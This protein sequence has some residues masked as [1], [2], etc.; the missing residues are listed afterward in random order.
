MGDYCGLLVL[1]FVTMKFKDSDFS[2]SMLHRTEEGYLTGRIRCTCSGV[3]RY[4]GTDGE[5]VRVLRSDT[6]V[7]DPSSVMSA[8][9]KPVTLQHPKDMVNAGNVKKYEVGFTGTD[10][11][12]YDGHLWLT[13]TVTDP[14][15]I[16]AIEKG[17]V[18]AV[19]MGYDCDLT[20]NDDPLNNWRGTEYTKEQHNIRYNHLALV[21]A[22]RA[23]ESVE[24]AIGDSIDAN[25]NIKTQRKDN[26]MRKIQIDSVEYEADEVVINAYKAAQKDSAE[27]QKAIDTLT[28]ERD[29]AKALCEQK[30]KEINALKDA[31]ASIDVKSMVKDRLALEKVADK[32][33]IENAAEMD[34]GAIKAAVIGKAFD[35][36][37]LEGKS[38]DYV[39]AMFDAACSKD[40][41]KDVKVDN[42]LDGDKITNKD[43]KDFMSDESVEDSRNA[44]AKRMRGEGDK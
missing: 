34:D 6:E 38:A 13:I 19:S 14:N 3:F 2:P 4:L 31:A 33:G 43:S 32:A 28:A 24:I 23:G 35:G 27:K 42:S 18:A 25:F 44:F 26:A 39:Q 20:D 8:N 37:S 30:D 41:K 10:A 36:I 40:F 21:Y 9:S 15:A 16:E 29:A 1:I 22:G 11:E 12:F 17:E 7:G 5:Y